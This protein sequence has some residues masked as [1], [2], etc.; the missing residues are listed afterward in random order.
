MKAYAKTKLPCHPSSLPIAPLIPSVGRVGRFAFLTFP[1]NPKLLPKR[2]FPFQQQFFDA[3][4]M[5]T[6]YGP[7]RVPGVRGR[8]LIIRQRI[9]QH[10]ATFGG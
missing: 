1:N 3:I 2:P 9:G 4:R 10:W 6:L 8:W 7:R 5:V